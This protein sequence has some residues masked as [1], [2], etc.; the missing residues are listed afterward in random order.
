VGVLIGL[1]QPVN[2]WIS[3]DMG[4]TI[5]S[6]TK[7]DGGDLKMDFPPFG[8]RQYFLNLAF[9]PDFPENGFAE[10]SMS[11]YSS[12]S[13]AEEE[14]PAEPTATTEATP[15]ES[16]E[17]SIDY[18]ADPETVDAGQCTT[19]YWKV[20]NVKNI[21][22]GGYNQEFEGSYNDCICMT[23]TY[24]MTITYLDDTTE[25]FYVT[26]EVN[27]SCAT[28]TP[29]PTD[30]PAPTETPKPA[31]PANPNG[32]NVNTNVCSA[33]TYNV[34]LTWNDNA[35]NEIGYRVYRDGQLI[36]TL[37]PNSTKYDDQPPYS[38]PHTYQIEAFNNDGSTF[39][40]MK[41]DQGCVY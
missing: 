7:V 20:A 32:F 28:A 21:E 18:Y 34:H 33:N 2:F 36:D 6:P 1:N 14:T 41:D 11:M 19:I 29:K 15:T 30:T 8:G 22:F 9:D 25:K 16:T 40:N 27:G 10:G 17:P 38:G 13:A 3:D 37:G 26:I 39:T 24:P 31:P 12:S 35:N 5:T 23:S 4:R